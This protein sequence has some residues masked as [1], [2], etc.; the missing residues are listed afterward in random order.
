MTQDNHSRR[1]TRDRVMVENNAQTIHDHL[2]DL[3]NDA[4]NRKRWLWELLQ[5][6]QDQSNGNPVIVNVSLSGDQLTFSHNGDPFTEDDIAHLIYHG[7]SKKEREG[8]TGKYGTGFMTTHLLSRKVRIRGSIENNQWFDFELV[9]TG[10]DSKEMARALDQSW[11]NF[12]TSIP[13]EKLTDTGYLTSFSYLEIGE[14]NTSVIEA[15]EQVPLLIP[16]VLAFTPGIKE[17]LISS[18]NITTYTW[19]ENEEGET[20]ILATTNGIPQ[21]YKLWLHSVNGEN[22]TI[23]LW[24]DSGFQL[25]AVETK[26]PR[27]FITF[28]LIGTEQAFSWPFLVHSPDFEPSRERDR[29]WLGSSDQEVEETNQA[30]TN[31][32][33]LTKVFKEYTKVCTS[34]IE[35][36]NAVGN[37]HLLAN[38]GPLPPAD[39][40]DATWYLG[41]V[42]ELIEILDDLPLV[43]NT[44]GKFISLNEAYIPFSI[45]G[46]NNGECNALHELLKSLWP[47]QTVDME[48]AAFWRE[49]LISRKTLYTSDYQHQ[50][51]F[52]LERLGAYFEQQCS[53][54]SE[55]GFQDLQLHEITA[56][57]FIQK[58]INTLEQFEHDDLW[59]DYP[60]L[61]SQEDHF[62]KAGDLK[63][64]EE[65]ITNELKDISHQ[66]GFPIRKE[67]L[68]ESLIIHSENHRPSVYERTTL[69]G[70]L[71]RKIK[72][73][74]SSSDIITGAG[75]IQLFDWLLREDQIP[76]LIGYPIQMTDDSI[77]KLGEADHVP[78]LPVSLWRDSLQSFSDLFPAEFIFNDSYVSIWEQVDLLEKAIQQNWVKQD[79]L[80]IKETLPKI[81]HIPLL[82]TRMKDKE[83]LADREEIQWEIA[84]KIPFSQVAYFSTP[85]DKNIIDLARKSKKNTEKL[86]QMAIAL[87]EEEDAGF[88]RKEVEL[89]EENDSFSVGI[90]PSQWLLQLKSRKWVYN[91]TT[92]NGENI[93]VESLLPYFDRNNN[94]ELYTALQ[95][96]KLGRFLYFMGIAVG[97]LIRNLR[98]DNEEE[99][100]NWD[101]S[102]VSILMNESLTPEKVKGLLGDP[103]FIRQYEE[104]KQQEQK[105]QQNQA[106]GE[107]VEN[108]FKEAIASLPGFNIKRQPVGSDYE[109]ECD[110][111]HY[112][113][114]DKPGAKS[115][116]IEIKS[117]RTQEVR[118]TITQGFKA[119]N[120]GATIYFLC[121]V[122]LTANDKINTDLIRSKAKF[123]TNIGELLQDRVKN[124]S[125]ITEQHFQEMSAANPENSLVR[126]TI[127]GTQVRYAV[128][129]RAWIQESPKAI[130][131]EAFTQSQIIN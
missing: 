71:V 87:L 121:V 88:T 109:I 123:V 85:D 72:G 47:D 102:Y 114:L 122:P 104:K 15:L 81:E 26:M 50:A 59:N 51:V 33:I 2:I 63:L 93:S 43:E 82:I 35:K 11:D 111:Q 21:E 27:I 106:V 79:P 118:M 95:N 23:A 107:A 94:P 65:A 128:H 103:D 83:K 18:G 31:K 24:L 30:N 78:L 8:K 52:T 34:L 120:S 60:I 55:F 9:R 38:L 42:R 10:R 56:L 32:R 49:V 73:V 100:M 46:N 39:K 115:I 125:K 130:S 110:F 117:A 70:Y 1:D 77:K 66:I 91:A 76:E 53:D 96:D 3:E 37:R 119:C 67:L 19:D 75:G 12:E 29:L 44:N 16:P 17:I 6:A 20:T 105:V 80:L 127:E 89:K 126:T 28:P 98:T 5:N 97:D 69:V 90:Y 74:D 22:A 40:V 116:L 84:H 64:Q 45:H 54:N 58:I 86:L 61:P 124:V 131:F 129:E 7:S 14:N 108:A 113:L 41:E 62:R 57:D 68:H 112:L 92:R 13:A 4:R 99:R 36:E 48:L 25:K 101:R